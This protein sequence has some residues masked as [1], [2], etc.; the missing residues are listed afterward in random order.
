MMLGARVSRTENYGEAPIAA[1]VPASSMTNATRARQGAWAPC[2]F[3]GDAPRGLGLGVE[4]S[5]TVSPLLRETLIRPRS[6]LREAWQAVR[7]RRVAHPLFVC[8]GAV[9]SYG[10]DQP[11][12]PIRHDTLDDWCAAHPQ[13]NAY[14]VVSG[15]ATHELVVKD[16][17]LP[18]PDEAA[19]I[20]WAAQQFVGRHGTVAHDWPVAPWRAAGRR[21][22]TAVHGLDLRA[23]EE[24]ARLNSVRL[25]AVQSWWPLAA[26]ATHRQL[27][28]VTAMSRWQL[29]IVEGM[30]LTRVISSMEAVVD[31]EQRW[32]EQPTL[33]ALRALLQS[34]LPHEAAAP[35]L[36]L[37]YG[38]ADAHAAALTGLPVQVLGAI[39]GACPAYSWISL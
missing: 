6:V 11:H 7:Q 31:V 1:G 36:M 14:L 5:Q 32:L 20:A 4:E 22:A 2:R 8:P 19:V 21:G 34:L 38:I 23:A 33:P 15:H 10:L 17:T 30:L 37:G 18:L 26:A 25:R 24:T 9:W 27:P 13:C 28:G 29:F 3:V 12:A 39:D 16:D 35:A